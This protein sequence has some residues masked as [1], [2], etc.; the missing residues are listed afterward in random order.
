MTDNQRMTAEQVAN[1]VARRAARPVLSVQMIYIIGTVHELTQ[2]WSDA[3]R[4]SE[5]IDT[6]SEI[7]QQF[8]QY[9][10]DAVGSLAA[11]ALAEELSQ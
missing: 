8:E 10:R 3:I 5:L 7:V 9:L 1:T 11:T 6:K 2:Y 4:R